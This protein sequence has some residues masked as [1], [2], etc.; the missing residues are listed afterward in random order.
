[1]KQIAALL[2]VVCIALSSNAQEKGLLAFSGKITAD[3]TSETLPFAHII[4]GSSGTTSNI[5]GEFSVMVNPG[6]SL[7]FSYL[8]Y[9]K[10]LVVIPKSQTSD[11]TNQEVMLLRD[12]TYLKPVTISNIPENLDDFKEV[13]L[14]THLPDSID[15]NNARKSISLTTYQYLYMRSFK[16]TMTDYDNYAM[17]L[18][19]NEGLNPAGGNIKGLFKFLKNRAK[20]IPLEGTYD[21]YKYYEKTKNE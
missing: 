2:L 6:D 15:L 19:G 10:K 17:F 16:L 18:K 4:I 21:H 12:I 3:D 8:G 5:Y 14:E 11:M 13:I 20:G 9:Q 1:M 7:L